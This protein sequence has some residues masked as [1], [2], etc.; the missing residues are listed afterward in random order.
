[1]IFRLSQKLNTRIKAGILT[2]VPLDE[3]PF[4]DWSAGMFL[5]R[6]LAVHPPDKHEGSVLH[7]ATGQGRH[8]RQQLHRTCLERHT[9]VHGGRW[10]AWRL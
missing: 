2:A 3:N 8:E 9:R 1:M 7:G 10:T 4:A 6:A 5:V